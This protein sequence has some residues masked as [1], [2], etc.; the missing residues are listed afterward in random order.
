MDVSTAHHLAKSTSIRSCPARSG[1]NGWSEGLRMHN[2]G[3]GKGRR[4]AAAGPRSLLTIIL[5]ET[6]TY[7]QTASKQAVAEIG[8]GNMP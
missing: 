7:A 4:W 1:G 5:Y 2:S 8:D 6:L 3:T